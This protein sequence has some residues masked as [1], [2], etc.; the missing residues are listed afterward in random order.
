MRFDAIGK[1]IK[2]SRRTVAMTPVS[3]NTKIRIAT[4]S[5]RAARQIFIGGTIK[6]R[7]PN[8]TPAIIAKLY[9]SPFFSGSVRNFSAG[10]PKNSQKTYSPTR[11]DTNAPDRVFVLKSNGR[12]PRT[13]I[14]L[15]TSVSTPT[16]VSNIYNHRAYARAVYIPKVI[17][18][19]P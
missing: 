2:G 18:K 12:G 15:Q 6:V 16:D 11:L 4:V 10:I 9:A 7:L 5:A 17:R 14:M 1:P 13:V 3:G 8:A 19:A